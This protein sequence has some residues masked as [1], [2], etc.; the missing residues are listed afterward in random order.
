MPARPLILQAEVLRVLR[1]KGCPAGRG[2]GV[3]AG[4]RKREKAQVFGLTSFR[5]SS[6]L[7][8]PPAGGTRSQLGPGKPG[9]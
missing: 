4:A 9:R 7:P 6:K 5:D 1:A 2:D 3:E 8:I